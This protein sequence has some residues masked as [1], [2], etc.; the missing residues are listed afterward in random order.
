MESKLREGIKEISEATGIE[1]EELVKKMN[2]FL[3]EDKKVKT[4]EQAFCKL[5]GMLRPQMRFGP[6]D[7]IT[8]YLAAINPVKKFTS[9]RDGKE[10]I[11]YRGALVWVSTEETE[12]DEEGEMRMAISR[13]Y[14]PDLPDLEVDRSYSF[15]A[16]VE[17][18]EGGSMLFRLPNTFK[19][20]CK[21]VDQLYKKREVRDFLATISEPVSKIEDRPY[22]I[23]CVQGTIDSINEGDTLRSFYISDV[24]GYISVKVVLT[25]DELIE[26]IEDDIA[27]LKTVVVIGSINRDCDAI[28]AMRVDILDTP[29]DA[30]DE[31]DLKW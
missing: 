1:P 6:T 9:N 4:Y 26:K 12:D 17:I 18:D 10:V 7:E 25:D 14:S 23:C 28:F 22:E 19:D 24:S 13:L 3:R 21:E 5:K 31:P 29:E 2:E 8:A 27:E 20:E 30:E 11:Y 15:K 16:N